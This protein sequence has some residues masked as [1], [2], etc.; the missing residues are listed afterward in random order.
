MTFH[1]IAVVRRARLTRD[2]PPGACAR[3]RRGGCSRGGGRNR[4]HHAP[5]N[6]G[7][8]HDRAG[9]GGQ[10]E[11]GRPAALVLVR[12]PAGPGGARPRARGRAPE[13]GEAAARRGD[14]RPLPVAAGGDWSRLRAL[15][16]RRPR[17]AEAAR[18]LASPEPG[19]AAPSRLCLPLVGKKCRRRRVLA[20]RG[21]AA[22]RLAGGRPGREH[23]LRGEAR[24][25]AA[26]HRDAARPARRGD[27]VDPA[28]AGP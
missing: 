19:R 27:G 16:R 22:S 5:P 20:R 23:P 26:V 10:A 15:A 18:R 4:G 9:R 2:E 28:A 21:N 13:Q 14:L 7:R 8:E 12:G 6:P 1:N 11:A 24:A 25:G 3:D 17:R